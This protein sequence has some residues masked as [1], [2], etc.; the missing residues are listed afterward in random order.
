MKKFSHSEL[1]R[2]LAKQL[3]KDENDI[4]DVCH[5]L[6]KIVLSEMTVDDI[7]SFVVIRD[8]EDIG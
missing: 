4:K 6:L 8:L 3:D 7:I 1:L 5:T 2:S